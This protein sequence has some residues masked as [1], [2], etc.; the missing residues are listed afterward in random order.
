MA[1]PE[2]DRQRPPANPREVWISNGRHVLHF[3]PARWNRWA[4][5]LE[6]TVSEW[7]PGE[8][9]P[10]LQLEP[11]WHQLQEWQ[12]RAEAS[13]ARKPGQWFSATSQSFDA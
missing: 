1:T 2:R 8:S 12:K 13:K 4:Q 10:L 5:E 11:Q 3:K 9:V 7:I 6:L